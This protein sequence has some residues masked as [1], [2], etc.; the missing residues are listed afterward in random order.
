MKSLFAATLLSVTPFLSVADIPVHCLHRQTVGTW[1]F[2]LG[3]NK[4]DDTLTCGHK[5]PDEVMT[6]VDQKV[7]YK[8]PN[9][10]VDSEYKVTLTNPNIATDEKGNKG[11]WTMIYDEGFEVNI[12]G[13]KF[14]SF[15]CYEPKVQNPSPD[16]NADFYSICDEVFSGWYHNNDETDWGCYV[17]KHI[18]G[19]ESVTTDDD[20]SIS[21]DHVVQPDSL[22][23]VTATHLLR[24]GAA[25]STRR[26][27]AS[28][29]LHS[30]KSTKVEQE[31][32][33]GHYDR[34]RSEFDQKK[35]HEMFVTDTAFIDVVNSDPLSKWTARHYGEKFESL[36]HG[37]L[38]Q[39][40]GKPK[41]TNRVANK[42]PFPSQEQVSFIG[43]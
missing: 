25:A 23:E 26:V 8:S 15:F 17:G 34:Q 13:R 24:S 6:M 37:D 12:N 18:G 42:D 27:A 4:N 9:F 16:E 43:K 39:M 11:T 40:L 19:G 32:V 14:F 28:I 2:K 35:N 30:A 38:R 20:S 10:S 36:T 29:N 22:L 7:R 31:H 3:S 41:Y 1:N 33:I 5:L 21:N